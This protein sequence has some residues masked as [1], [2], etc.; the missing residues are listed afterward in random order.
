MKY[1][2]PT[3]YFILSL[4]IVNWLLSSADVLSKL[5]ALVIAVLTIFYLYE[6]YKGVRLDNKKKKQELDDKG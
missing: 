3:Y 5:A 6:K 2:E 4:S 1:F